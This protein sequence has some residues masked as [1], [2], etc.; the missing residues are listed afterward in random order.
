MSRTRAERTFA[1]LLRAFPAAFRRQFGAEMM[2]TFAEQIETARARERAGARFWLSVALD[3]VAHGVMERLAAV[4]H[5]ARHP[6]RARMEM[7]REE[8]VQTIMGDL[9][10]SARSLWRRPGFATTAVLTLALGIGVT[11]TMFG[12]V[13]TVVLRPLPYPAPERLVVLTEREATHGRVED[14]AATT[15]Q[16]W[17]ERSRSFASLAAW[18]IEERALTGNEEPEQVAVLRVSADIFRVLDVMPA[19]GRA[20]DADEETKGRERV[21][22][23][24]HAMWMRRFGGARV[25]G[26]T[27]TLNDAAYVV[28]GIMPPGFRFTDQ[29]PEVLVPLAFER[30]ELM[31]RAKRMF[32]VVGRLASGV[33][34][35]RATSEMRAIALAIAGAHPETN[36]GWTVD[37]RAMS[38]TVREPARGLMLLFGAVGFVL[39]I[40]CA[41]VANL[42]LARGEARRRELAI[43]AALGASRARLVRQLLIETLLIA[44][45]GGMLGVALSSMALGA[46]PAVLPLDLPRWSEMRID[47]RVIG[48]A[49]AATSVAA[50]LAGLA[51]ALQLTA[52][53]HAGGI[54]LGARATG[55]RGVRR[56]RSVLV[57]AEVALAFMLLA[58]ATLLLNSLRE[59]TSV[60]PGFDPTARL[61]ANIQLVEERYQNDA[62]Q[63]AFFELLIERVRAIP[64]VLGAGAVTTLPLSAGGV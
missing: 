47:G 51:P 29:E 21:A 64:G 17:R 14:V 33:Q 16:D 1:L 50:V 11:T 24:G 7:T 6:H 46:L 5:Q 9:R 44:A 15:F 32:N 45:I 26:S 12:V 63:V 3:V 19:V 43:R 55:S 49:L 23:L 42:L 22:I 4:R 60:D 20:F 37:V 18:R 10:L 40:A 48:F 8:I 58:G 57:G 28:V 27:I 62:Q 31:S 59:V 52:G 53:R 36:D 30:F 25:L 38:E 35:P 13:N 54:A 34:L 56:M 2:S 41:N 39:L 61:V